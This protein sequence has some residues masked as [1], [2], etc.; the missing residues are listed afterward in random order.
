MMIK[1]HIFVDGEL[2]SRVSLQHCPAK[3]DTLR[4]QVRGATTESYVL[5]TEVIWCINEMSDDGQRVNIRT[6]SESDDG[7]D[8]S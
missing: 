2:R 5:V 6:E 7:D 3:G 4:L 1:A 8:V